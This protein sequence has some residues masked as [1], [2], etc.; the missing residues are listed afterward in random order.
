MGL[1]YVKLGRTV[2][3][4]L[5]HDPW[6]Y[7]LE[8]DSDGW[9][10]V[11]SLLA[12]LRQKSPVWRE[13]RE[14]DLADMIAAS[15]KQRHEI[16]DGRIRAMYGHSLPGKLS[17]RAAAPPACLFHGTAPACIPMIRQGGLLPMGRQYVHLSAERETAQ[18]VGRRKASKPVILI[19]RANE[20]HRA[21]VVFYEGND[22]VWLADC[23][24]PEFIEW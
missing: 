9:V 14:S 3:H 10:S 21:G 2:S 22:K 18:A 24:P 4:A 16:A 15:S 20:A 5:R 23:I 11:D 19:V 8:I 1:D 17:M 12:A 13:L 7:E 6:L